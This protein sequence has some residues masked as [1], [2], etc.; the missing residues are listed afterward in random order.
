MK[1]VYEV[2][3]EN[4]ISGA[5]DST[6]FDSLRAAEKWKKAQERA[7]RKVYIANWLVY[8]FKDI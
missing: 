1:R 4:V 2:T 7:N 5:Q 8:S 3:T 6:Y